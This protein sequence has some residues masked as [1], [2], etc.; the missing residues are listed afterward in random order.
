MDNYGQ[1][2]VCNSSI[3]FDGFGFSNF[4]KF[5]SCLDD[6][7]VVSFSK[8]NVT[9]FENSDKFYGSFHV[10]GATVDID[11]LL[12]STDLL[13]VSGQVFVSSSMKLLGDV[14]VHTDCPSITSEEINEF[15]QIDEYWSSYCQCGFDI[16]S[17]VQI[18]NITIISGIITINSSSLISK[19]SLQSPASFLFIP[20]N[21]KPSI[22]PGP[23]LNKGNV[24]GNGTLV[25][26]NGVFSIILENV[27]II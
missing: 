12:F 11:C 20:S 24:V 9:I 13:L 6:H 23:F 27:L 25:L 3:I 18:S 17:S 14:I 21:S 8:G 22:M 10:S 15:L 4:G 26:D 5:N 19:L 16:Q 1:I 7:S 2:H